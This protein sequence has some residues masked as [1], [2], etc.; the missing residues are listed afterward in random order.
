MINTELAE[1][2]K[3]WYIIWGNKENFEIIQIYLKSNWVYLNDALH[4]NA[5]QTS[6]NKYVVGNP[7]SRVKTLENYTEISFD[8]FKKWIMKEKPLKTDTEC[9]FIIKL[10]EKYNIK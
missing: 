10:L 5:G 9:A 8:Q 1:L 3:R 4:S 2:P 6:D 7:K